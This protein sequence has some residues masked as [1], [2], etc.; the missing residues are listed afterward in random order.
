MPDH[1]RYGAVAECPDQTQRVP[2]Q[3]EHAERAEVAVVIAVPARGASVA[4]LVGS[5]HVKPGGGDGQQHLSPAVRQFRE[6]VEEQ[7]A[8]PVLDVEAGFQDVHPEAVDVVHEAGAYTGRENR[9]IVSNHLGQLRHQWLFG[10]IYSLTTARG[11]TRRFRGA[12]SCCRH[13]RRTDGNEA[14]HKLTAREASSFGQDDKG[15]G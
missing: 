8:G 10:T 2:D 12:S 7:D 3:V 11:F 15:I 9:L 4:P 1:S 5:D 14:L 6:A 13:N